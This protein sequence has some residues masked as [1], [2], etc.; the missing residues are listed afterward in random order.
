MEQAIEHGFNLIGLANNHSQ[1]CDLGRAF[2]NSSQSLHGPLMSAE[3]LSELKGDFLWHGVGENP[4]SVKIKEMFVKGR[5]IKVAFASL[6]LISWD[7]PNSSFINFRTDYEQKLESFLDG[8]NIVADLKILAIHTQDKSGHQKPEDEAYLLM[9]KIGEKFINKYG[10][11]IV[12]GQGAHT[13]GGVKV[14]EANK[15]KSVFVTSLGNFIHDG[16]RANPDNY[17]AKILLSTDDLK[18]KQIQIL[19]FINNAGSERL[20]FYD[21]DCSRIDN[22]KSNFVLRKTSIQDKCHYFSSF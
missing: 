17:I 9:K 11:D 21:G 22:L 19:P 15:K 5:K 8:F 18:L 16:L 3:A 10:G 13:Y 6:S 2:K 7:I 14:I 12:F 1:D 4:M 20:K